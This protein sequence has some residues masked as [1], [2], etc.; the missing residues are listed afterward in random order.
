MIKIEI[1]IN[2][3]KICKFA[4]SN[5]HETTSRPNTIF[6]VPA[7]WMAIIA[8]A[9][10][11]VYLPALHGKFTNWDDMVYVGANPFIKITIP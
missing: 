11:I 4:Y 1:L 2:Q 10:F 7:F 5:G 8:I 3:D 6:A 9:T